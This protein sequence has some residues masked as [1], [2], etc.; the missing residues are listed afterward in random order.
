MSWQGRELYDILTALIQG[1]SQAQTPVCS[2]FF[3]PG[4]DFIY[5]MC[6]DCGRDC[7]TA[8]VAI[9]SVRHGDDNSRC[10]TGFFVT[11]QIGVTRCAPVGEERPSDDEITELSSLLLSDMNVMREALLCGFGGEALPL[12]YSPISPQGGCSGGQWSF[13]IA[14]GMG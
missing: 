12:L 3:H 14:V 1:L 2:A 7:G 9:S 13:E 10:D 4:S 5:Q 8:W 6:D 11:G